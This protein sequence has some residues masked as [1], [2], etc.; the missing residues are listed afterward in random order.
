MEVN[1]YGS[2]YMSI[3]K[4]T[5]QLL[6]DNFAQKFNLSTTQVDLFK[7]YAEMLV[8]WNKVMNLTTIVDLRRIISDHFTDS[9]VLRNNLDFSTINVIL[10]IGTGAGFP[11]LPLK[12]MY[13][14]LKVILLEVNQ[15]KQ[16]F[17]SAVIDELKLDSVDICG[18][19][20]KTFVRSTDAHIDLAL[21]RA[22]LD[23]AT[24]IRIF[25]GD[26][27]YKNVL[28]VYWASK[29]WQVTQDEAPYIIAQR[30]YTIDKKNRTL[31][32]MG[33]ECNATLLT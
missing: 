18:L 15:K 9:C 11:G 5:D 22:S 33:Q 20:F 24:L 27:S 7:K 29:H 2:Y 10:D 23:P 32:F 16:R 17:L 4:P 30:S 1:F 19:D 3:T 12:I 25:G 8:S 13:P 14:H 26:S 28:L 6:W 31:V 21:A